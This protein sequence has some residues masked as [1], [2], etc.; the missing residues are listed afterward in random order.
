MGTAIRAALKS[1]SAASKHV[2]PLTSVL[3]ARRS[4]NL[5]ND[6]FTANHHILG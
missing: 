5:K 2:R 3:T 1:V 6:N 4:M